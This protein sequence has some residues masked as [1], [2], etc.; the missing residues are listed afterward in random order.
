MQRKGRGVRLRTSSGPVPPPLLPI[1][2]RLRTSGA[3]AKGGIDQERHSAEEDI[4]AREALA[5]G[6]TKEGILKGGILKG[7]ILKGGIL[8]KV[9]RQDKGRRVSE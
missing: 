3:R 5:S 6:R 4:I 7:G 1:V 2:Q 9:R 8:K